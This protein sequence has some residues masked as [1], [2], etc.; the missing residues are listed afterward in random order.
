MPPV[1]T[2]NSGPTTVDQTY[3]FEWNIEQYLQT[4]KL[5][6]WN[7]GEG[8][9]WWYKIEWKIPLC[10]PHDCTPSISV[11][12]VLQPC[13]KCDEAPH[14]PPCPP[15]Q[16]QI[17]DGPT[18][19][20]CPTENCEVWH[21]QA[22]SV[23]DL[24]RRLNRECCNRFLYKKKVFKKV[25]KYD[26]PALCCDVDMFII[27]GIPMTDCYIEVD[28][29]SCECVS[30]V[31]PCDCG[32]Y[33]TPCQDDVPFHPCTPPSVLNQLSTGILWAMPPIETDPGFSMNNIAIMQP[34]EDIIETKFGMVPSNLTL[35]H[36]LENASVLKEFLARNKVK[37]G[38]LDLVYSKASKAWQ[39]VVHL[40]GHNEK[41]TL[42]F[43][44]EQ[45]ADVWNLDINI[46]NGKLKT[47][48]QTSYVP[49]GVFDAANLDY[50]TVNNKVTLKQQ[51]M[52]KKQMVHDEIGLFKGNWLKNPHLKF[53]IIKKG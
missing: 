53:D 17:C 45:L 6:T 3:N 4:P 21:V 44:W 29:C 25:Y 1:I 9:L 5:L 49:R 24:C 43:S 33:I 42:A 51:A 28:F 50:N 10:P 48:I 52:I 11:C 19:A 20:A 30:W 15:G 47:R 14:I 23:I 36:N 34:E 7:V 16:C 8:P 46:N 12:E 2:T 18:P 41:W 26:R 27:K 35:R 39:K 22:T 38:D 37:V 13:P 32:Y 31:D 40:K